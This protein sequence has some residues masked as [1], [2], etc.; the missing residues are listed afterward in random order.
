MM[1]DMAL[2]MLLGLLA[3]GAVVAT[4]IY[5]GIRTGVGDAGRSSDALATL[6]RRLASGE[7]S[8]EEYREREAAI[9]NREAGGG[10]GHG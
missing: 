1:G 9:R 3:V 8:V 5:L 2:W 7:I 6:R 4:A 10:A